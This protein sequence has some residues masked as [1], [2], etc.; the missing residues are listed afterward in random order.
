MSRDSS[1]NGVE[2][3]STVLGM[4]GKL[5]TARPSLG[6]RV[7]SVD[8]YVTS[9]IYVQHIIEIRENVNNVVC[10]E[11]QRDVF[12]VTLESVDRLG[13]TNSTVVVESCEVTKSLCR[14]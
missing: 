9:G 11:C 3:W 14:S 6:G 4:R 12:Y 7:E 1:R 8:G 2:S 5:C 13:V 10:C